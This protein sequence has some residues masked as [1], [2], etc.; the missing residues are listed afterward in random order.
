MKKR[1][2]SVMMAVAM[3]GTL[4]TG[5]GDGKKDA[6]QGTEAMGS[7]DSTPSAELESGTVELKIWSDA[8]TGIH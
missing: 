1:I 6:P 7:V 8:G 5:C 3:L 4:V 2:I